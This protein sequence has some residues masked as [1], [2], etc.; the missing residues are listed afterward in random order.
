MTL[1]EMRSALA[2]YRASADAQGAAFKDSHLALF[3]LKKLYVRLDEPE[4]TLANRV[5]AEWLLS[6]DEGLR[7]DA[8]TL[9][10]EFL[11]LTTSEALQE[12]A[13]RLRVA[14]TP[15]APYE[16][17]RVNRVLHAVA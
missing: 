3:E 7:F 5:I 16:L 10:E 4:R 2:D 11:I 12:L 17:K 13:N 6:E 9:A 14:T 15:G 8:L 1:D